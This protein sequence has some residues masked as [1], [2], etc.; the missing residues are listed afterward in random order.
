[1][2]TP[3][4][5]MRIEVPELE[6]FSAEQ[7]EEL[8]NAAAKSVRATHGR[9]SNVPHY[10]GCA[11]TAIS[12][13]AFALTNQGLV[14]AT[15]VGATVYLG[16]LTIGFLLLRYSLLRETRRV[17]RDLIARAAISTASPD[18]RAVKDPLFTVENTFPIKGRGLVLF[19]ITIDQYGNVQVGDRLS[20]KRPD[21]STILA[22]V[23]GIDYPPGAKWADNPPENP[24]YGVLIES[25]D[26]IPIGSIASLLPKAERG[27]PV[28]PP[29]PPP[30]G[31]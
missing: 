24:R 4:M 19:G 23:R 18:A 8:L 29:T 28:D 9:M 27:Q 3:L 10:I 12:V 5:Q 25:S 17:L 11:L 15:V 14:I 20:I 21:A 7:Q 6:G 22:E 1:M 2:R 30:G 26:D 16:C 13:A 31:P